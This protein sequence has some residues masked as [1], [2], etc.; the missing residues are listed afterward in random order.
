MSLRSL[1]HMFARPPS[2]CPRE[3]A[4]AALSQVHEPATFSRYDEQR[5]RADRH[6]ASQTGLGTTYPLAWSGPVDAERTMRL[7]MPAGA[8]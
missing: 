8:R 4:K 6:L 7:L 5:T 3:L 2:N 1:V